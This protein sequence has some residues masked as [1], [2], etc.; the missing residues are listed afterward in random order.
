MKYLCV[1]V[2]IP[3]NAK[4]GKERTHFSEKGTFELR[5]K[6]CRYFPGKAE[7]KRKMTFPCVQRLEAGG[8]L[9][10]CASLKKRGGTAV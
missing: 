1:C 6:Q 8:N 4:K 3:R 5:T 9:I 7:V 2:C 10:F